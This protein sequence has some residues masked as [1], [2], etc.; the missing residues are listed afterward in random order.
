[1]QKGREKEGNK[2]HRQ[3]GRIRNPKT[4]FPHG[5]RDL[6]VYELVVFVRNPETS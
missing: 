5:D 2:G 3:N 1:M 4:S 6:T